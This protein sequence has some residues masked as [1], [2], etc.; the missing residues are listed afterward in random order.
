MFDKYH[1]KYTFEYLKLGDLRKDYL[2]QLVDLALEVEYYNNPEFNNSKIHTSKTF[3][4][5]IP[6]VKN[7]I[8]HLDP[9]MKSECFINCHFNKM[10]PMAYVADHS[11]LVAT[12][13][14]TITHKIHIAVITNEKCGHMWPR[15]EKRLDSISTHF[16]AGGVYLYNNVDLHSAV[17][18]SDQERIHLIM[19]YTR[20]ATDLN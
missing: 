7:I 17:N 15:A 18:L 8:D 11:D 10:L 16:E 9:M 2:D 1:V 4:K 12:F 20:E 19:R 3:N 6:L 13:W 5:S 14:P